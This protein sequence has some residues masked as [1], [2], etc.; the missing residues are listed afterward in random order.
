MSDLYSEFKEAWVDRAIFGSGV[1]AR[2]A[3]ARSAMRAQPNYDDAKYLA[4][5]FA[6]EAECHALLRL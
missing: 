1:A 3:K 5:V 2:L 6:A 4:A